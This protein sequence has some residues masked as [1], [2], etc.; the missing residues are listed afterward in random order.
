MQQSGTR[1]L[2]ER[3]APDGRLFTNREQPISKCAE[4]LVGESESWKK[5][6][7]KNTKRKPLDRSEV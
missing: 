2:R 3:D 4:G 1:K 7:K 6:T 5:K